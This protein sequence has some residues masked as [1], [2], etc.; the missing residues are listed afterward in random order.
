MPCCSLF[1]KNHTKFWYDSYPGTTNKGT[2]CRICLISKPQSN[3]IWTF[4]KYSTKHGLLG[5]SDKQTWK[6]TYNKMGEKKCTPLLFW[7][8][9]RS[10]QQ[11]S[12]LS[13]FCDELRKLSIKPCEKVTKERQ[14]NLTFKIPQPSIQ[15]FE[16]VFSYY[17]MYCGPADLSLL[18]TYSVS[19]DLS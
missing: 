3:I 13:W 9:W 5:L 2:K 14:C 7:Q 10:H 11:L 1:T 4:L 18:D 8:S 15:M 19:V 6:V 12:V 17:S 16:T